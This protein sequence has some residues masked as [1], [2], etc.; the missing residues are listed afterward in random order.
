M[1]TLFISTHYNAPH[2]IKFQVESFNIFIKNDFEIV[3]MDDSR[4]N[5][6]SLFSERIASEEIYEESQKY[7]L[8]YIR[9][10][11]SIHTTISNG[12]LVPDGLPC[13]HPTERH[14][15]H[16]HWI[17]KNHKILG[18]DKYNIIV[19]IE[20]DMFA[21]KSIDIESYMGDYDLMGPGRKNIHLVREKQNP[22]QEWALQSQHLDEITISFFPMYMLFVNMQRVNN[23]ET[24]DVGGFAGTDTGGKTYFF[25]QDNPQYKYFFM[26]IINNREYQI[27]FISKF[28]FTGKEADFIH[29]RAGSNWDYQNEEYYQEKL[30]RLFRDFVPEIKYDY[31]LLKHNLISR[32]KEHTFFKEE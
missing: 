30:K 16:L 31:H 13:D 6:K 9:V 24:L 22:N 32:D 17:I 29:Y 5:M 14:R 20:S 4:N 21:K 2:F 3:I 27:D 12:G 8:R 19:F 7:D 10:P 11:Q 23:L 26:E 18:F 15:A 25:L 1:K 28:A